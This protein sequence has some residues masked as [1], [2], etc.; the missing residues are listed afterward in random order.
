[1]SCAKRASQPD[2]RHEM[3][4]AFASDV[5]PGAT[6]RRS[7]WE[8]V[9]VADPCEVD[10]HDLEAARQRDHLVSVSN[11]IYDV[12]PILQSE[13]SPGVMGVGRPR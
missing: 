7:R 3:V 10:A 13:K 1:M 5:E 2:Q 9:S 6:R 11:D 4:L 12:F 8:N